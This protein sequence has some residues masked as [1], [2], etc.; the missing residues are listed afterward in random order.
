M[1]AQPLLQ[2]LASKPF[3]MLTPTIRI[4]N[5]N[6]IYVVGEWFSAALISFKITYSQRWHKKVVC[7]LA[8]N[9]HGMYILLIWWNLFSKLYTDLNQLF[10]VQTDVKR[11]NRFD[12]SLTCRLSHF[13]FEWCTWRALILSARKFAVQQNTTFQALLNAKQRCKENKNLTKATMIKSWN[14]KI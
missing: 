6:S 12:V 8:N 10:V 7:A 1:M 13:R 4:E 3:Q 2:S 5:V 14:G 9:G 11:H